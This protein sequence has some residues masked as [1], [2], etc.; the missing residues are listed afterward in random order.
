MPPSLS[1][2]E[3]EPNQAEQSTTTAS[4]RAR[5]ALQLIDLLNSADRGLAQELFSELEPGAQQLFD[6]SFEYLCTALGRCEGPR[7]CD[8]SSDEARFVSS[9]EKGT[10]ELDPQ[11]DDEGR[12][13]SLISGASN[14]VPPAEVYAAASSALELL[15]AWDLSAADRRFA[16]KYDRGQ[17]A[18]LFE[19]TRSAWGPCDLGQV[20]LANPRGAIFELTCGADEHAMRFDLDDEGRFRRFAFWERAWVSVC[21]EAK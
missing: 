18:E 10:W 13:I 3:P 5:V 15:A 8:S 2:P 20:H 12:L 6:E 19:R 4:P 16:D 17:L 1:R 14:V 11:L 21:D 9:C 7:P